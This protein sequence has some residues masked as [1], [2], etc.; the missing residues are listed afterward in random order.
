MLAVS[1][2]GIGLWRNGHG[3]RAGG[4]GV[5]PGT[6]TSRLEAL[7]L[8]LLRHPE[9]AR[10]ERLSTR[11]GPVKLTVAAVARQLDVSVSTA[12][13]DLAQ[14]QAQREIIRDEASGRTG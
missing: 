8:R 11:Q 13:R 5:P 12:R 9:S 3:S 4:A 6:C 7:R 14:L 2:S 10:V 1:L